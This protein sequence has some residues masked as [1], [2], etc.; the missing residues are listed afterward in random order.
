MARLCDRA[1]EIPLPYLTQSRL[2]FGATQSL[3][4]VGGEAAPNQQRPAPQ[5]G[6]VCGA[7][8][9]RSLYLPW[10]T[11]W[12]PSFPPQPRRK[13]RPP[14]PLS[15]P[16]LCAFAEQTSLPSTSRLPGAQEWSAAQSASGAAFSNGE[17]S[18]SR[19]HNHLVVSGLEGPNIEKEAL[20]LHPADDGRLIASKNGLQPGGRKPP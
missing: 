12:P 9:I 2:P 1:E 13:D 14:S 3:E 18:G 10:M 11:G 8:R 4:P 15:M 16:R 7:K 6:M 19:R 20:L 5:A 17:K